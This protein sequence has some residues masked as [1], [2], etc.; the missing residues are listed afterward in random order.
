MNG[1]ISFG[2]WLRQQRKSLDLTQEALADQ[3]GC[4]KDTIRKIELGSRRASKQVTE[5]LAQCFNV[6]LEQQQVF[7]R[8]ARGSGGDPTLS[9]PSTSQTIT[10]N[11][12]RLSA[13]PPNN[14]PAAPTPLIGREQELEKLTIL[15]MREG[16]RMVTL[17]GP[18]G[19]GKT[20]LA[21]H[22]AEKL[23]VQED[24]EDGVF[25]VPLASIRDPD[26]LIPAISHVL[27]VHEIGNQPL[28]D[29]L[30]HYLHGKQMLLLLDN[31]EQII[32][33]SLTVADLLSASAGLKVLATS[34]QLLDL[35][36]EYKFPVPA[37]DMP[38]TPA[39]NHEPPELL[40]QYEAVRLFTE[41]SIAARPDFEL[42][43]ENA[44]AVAEICVRLDGLPL[45]IELAAARVKV[46]PL[47]AMLSRLQNRLKLLTGGAQDLPARQQT[48]RNTIEWSYDLLNEGEKYLFRRLAVF[49]GGSTLEGLG[50]VCTYDGQLQIDIVD[51]LDSLIG[52]SL[53]RQTEGRN[54][55]P[56]FWMLETIHELAREKLE[57]SGEAEALERE[58]ALYFMG[59]AEEAEPQIRGAKQVEWLDRLDDEHDNFRAAL[60]WVHREVRKETENG[61]ECA[62]EES[63]AVDMGLRIVGNLQ[64]FWANRTYYREGRQQIKTILDLHAAQGGP[65]E[66][67]VARGVA[68]LGA[69][70]LAHRQGELK[71]SYALAEEA[72][73]LFR[74]AG[75]KQQIARA[76]LS[77]AASTLDSDEEIRLLEESRP[78]LEEIGD[79]W[80]LARLFYRYG[81]YAMHSQGDFAAA[82]RYFERC[83]V[84]SEQAGDPAIIALCL[85]DLGNVARFRHELDSAKSYYERSLVYSRQV[86]DKWA[87][88]LALL[89]LTDVAWIQGDYSLVRPFAEEARDLFQ[90]V[91]DPAFAAAALLDLGRIA[92][93]EGDT[94]EARS[95][96]ERCLLE[97]RIESD[98]NGWTELLVL[99]YL[100][101]VARREGNPGE[102]GDLYTRSLSVDLQ[103]NRPIKCWLF[104]GTF[105]A[106]GLLTVE[107]HEIERAIN[108][109]AIAQALTE[110]SG[111]SMYY[112]ERSEYERS[113]AATRV[114]VVDEST[115]QAV[116]EQ[117][118][119]MS[120]EQAIDYAIQES[121][122]E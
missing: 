21:L 86:R 23:L 33:A 34:R 97:K 24:F 19:I 66:R 79:T 20:R 92:L 77:L 122:S 3:I 15:V 101:H 57:E 99:R 27:G 69:Q 31:F 76:L 54:G 48:L 16:V 94:N 37:L 2:E 83:L 59:L 38:V 100:G 118:H 102:A 30:K 73:R 61:A 62:T 6:P 68:L 49:R 18:G 104:A 11:S 93:I 110:A 116:W 72:L 96:L 115:W 36:S 32:A 56:R 114:W 35:Q 88:A 51:G 65:A 120:L 42:T 17:T 82:K 103:V 108:L 71:E 111:Q 13:N 8:F 98:S 12:L 70:L 85:L 90:E 1:D 14:L 105:A 63:L 55:E 26:L 112:D 41:R 39:K 87:T 117:G 75:D 47:Q 67:R 7:M 95:L 121:R 4:S 25:F 64:R 53:L 40:T 5:L 107:A 50:R 45:A 10:N 89:N 80:D 74:A 84:L 9:I 78:L 119:A 44:P 22:V 81:Q 106:L 28:L 60:A 113:L 91:G 52:K 43:N 46:L 109:L 29:I 58:H